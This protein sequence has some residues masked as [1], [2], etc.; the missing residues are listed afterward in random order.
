[1]ETSGILS[2]GNCTILRII[3]N[4]KDLLITYY[5]I[6]VVLWYSSLLINALYRFITRNPAETRERNIHL[7]YEDVELKG[8]F[9]ILIFT[10]TPM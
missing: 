9:E 1:M 6:E 4:I 7:A 3:T 5:C 8:K 10:I 2:D